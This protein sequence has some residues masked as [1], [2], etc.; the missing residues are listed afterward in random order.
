MKM[1]MIIL[2][3]IQAFI[4]V[5][6]AKYSFKEENKSDVVPLAEFE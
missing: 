6:T 5:E 2:T 1:K 4:R 3:R